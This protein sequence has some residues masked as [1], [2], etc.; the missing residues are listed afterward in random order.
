MFW[1]AHES[2]KVPG[3]VHK[4]VVETESG[5]ALALANSHTYIN[6]IRRPGSHGYLNHFYL[7]SI[8]LSEPCYSTAWIQP[9]NCKSCDGVCTPTPAAGVVTSAV[10]GSCFAHRLCP[11]RVYLLMWNLSTPLHAR[12]FPQASSS[13]RGG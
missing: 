12:T 13:S 11:V 3:F 10:W 9:G 5:V 2:F 8:Y 4:L 6:D 7:H 1:S